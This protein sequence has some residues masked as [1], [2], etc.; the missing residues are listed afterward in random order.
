MK[1]ESTVRQ[2]KVQKYNF[3]SNY[4]K[5]WFVSAKP[6][7]Q[8][9][10]KLRNEELLTRCILSNGH[11]RAM[12]A[13]YTV[14]WT[15]INTSPKVGSTFLYQPS[16]SVFLTYRFRD[17]GSGP[18]GD[19]WEYSHHRRGRRGACPACR[20][21]LIGSLLHQHTPHSGSTIRPHAGD[22]NHHISHN[23]NNYAVW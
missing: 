13:L 21:D 7:T 23:I 12:Y 22:K 5:L 15:L 14:S 8:T 9:T 6:L 4:L 10:A 3:S 16:M 19:N 11:R 2:T 20:S 17:S 1:Q 18:Q